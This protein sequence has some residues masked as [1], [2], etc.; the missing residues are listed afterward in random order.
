MKLIDQTPLQDEEGQIGIIQ[1]IQGTLKY[2]LSW[3]PE[4][5][6][7]K[8]TLGLLERGLAKGYTVIRNTALGASG[9]VIPLAIVGP[10]GIFV[11]YVTHLRGQYQAKGDS[12]GTLSGESFKPAAVNLL[13]RT[14]RYARAL[15]AFIERQG[16]ELPKPVEPVLLTAN[17]GMH[18]QSLRPIVK[19][20]MVDALE[21]WAASL[22]K[23]APVYTVESAY[24]LADRI[25]HP[26]PPKEISEEDT[27]PP[28]P[29]TEPEVP[30][31]QA[32]EDPELS[33]AGAIFAAADETESI[34]PADLEFA[35]EED[36]ALEVPPDLIE[37]SPAVPGLAEKSGPKRYLGMTIPQLAL[38]GGMLLVEMCVLIGFAIIFFL[39]P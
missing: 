24:E 9:I 17:P 2:G 10:A 13:T 34:D 5:E 3:Y 26:R 8:F 14:E 33:R 37:T 20:V 22:G 21:R 16:V 6:A 7:Q 30:A 31:P 27:V 19:V 39:N 25:V 36:S 15:Q 1:R 35:F 28:S 32:E 12:W 38:L 29:E 18:V 11:A 23:N 4:L